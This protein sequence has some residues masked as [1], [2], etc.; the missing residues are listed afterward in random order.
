MVGGAIARIDQNKCAGCGLCEN[1]CAYKAIEMNKE[2]KA[3]IKEALCKGC[4]TCVTTCRMEAPGLSGFS[5]EQVLAM[6]ENA[7]S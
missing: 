3:E 1:V 5:D 6:I 2:G 7:V 4:G